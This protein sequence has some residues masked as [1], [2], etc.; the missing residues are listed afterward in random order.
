MKS[1][2]S[3]LGIGII[4]L[5]MLGVGGCGKKHTM[6]PTGTMQLSADHNTR[7]NPVL[8]DKNTSNEHVEFEI[9]N[10]QGGDCTRVDRDTYTFIANM[11]DQTGDLGDEVTLY[12]DYESNEYVKIKK[13]LINGVKE[14]EY[15][16]ALKV[17]GIPIDERGLEYYIGTRFEESERKRQEQEELEAKPEQENSKEKEKEPKKPFFA[18]EETQTVD[19]TITDVQFEMIP[20]MVNDD[21]Q[22]IPIK[23]VFGNSNSDNYVFISSETGPIDKKVAKIHYKEFT[24]GQFSFKDLI[25]NRVENARLAS[26]MAEITDSDID[27]KPIPANGLVERIEYNL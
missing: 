16:S 12:S 19:V 10:V 17:I 21:I 6:E 4:A 27:S 1:T 8:L 2:T 24:D 13:R 20:Y 22:F 23:Y 14:I 18:Y 3:K 7:V 25:L 26:A 5:A 11:T 15:S 9:C